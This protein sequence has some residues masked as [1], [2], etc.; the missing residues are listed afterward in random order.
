MEV[1]SWDS[2]Q[3]RR[4][5]PCSSRASTKRRR[6]GGR[7]SRRGDG[8]DAGQIICH[9]R[10]PSPDRS[11]RRRAILPSCGGNP[12]AK[13]PRPN[14]RPWGRDGTPDGPDEISC[15]VQSTVIRPIPRY[16]SP[17]TYTPDRH[18]R[19]GQGAHVSSN[20]PGL[21]IRREIGRY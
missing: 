13:T 6:R 8:R 21:C 10:P 2:G 16:G 3:R 19:K 17:L 1:P 15:I 5:V 12:S 4:L 7:K 11:T 14:S 18:A 20:L 9:P